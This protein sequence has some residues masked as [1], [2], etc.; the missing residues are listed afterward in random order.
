MLS[1]NTDVLKI[2]LEN[3]EEYINDLDEYRDYI[4]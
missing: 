4:N 2:K 1:E 3:L